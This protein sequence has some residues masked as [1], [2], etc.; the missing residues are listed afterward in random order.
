MRAVDASGNRSGV[1]SWAWTVDK[2]APE[3]SFTDAPS[4][5]VASTSAT[6]EFTSTE[7]G[8]FTCTLDGSAATCGSPRNYSALGQ[9]S[10][11]FAV[12]ATDGAGNTDPTPA[13]RTWTV[14]TVAPDTA[15]TGGPADGSSTTATSA[16]FGLSSEAGAQFRCQ[17]DSGTIESCTS[18]KGYSGLGLGQHTVKAWARDAVGNEDASPAT[19]TWTVV[20]AP[21]PP[22]ASVVP[23]PASLSFGSQA[24]G[25]IGAARTLTLTNSGDAA[26][27]V[28]RMKIVGTNAEDFLSAAD[29]CVGETIAPHGT[30]TV[31]LRFAPSDLDVRSAVL[32]VFGERGGRHARGA[33]DRDRGGARGARHRPSRSARAGRPG[34]AHR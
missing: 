12:A 31:K 18:P 30:C 19:R 5:T 29:S 22:E 16:T 32:Q 28:A 9:G 17:L 10:H 15:L 6:F 2:V 26:L 23:S 21:P 33:L 14:D 8:T 20:A 25:T 7:S 24:L 34:R 27:T 11:T 4:G 1:S 13:T 3:T